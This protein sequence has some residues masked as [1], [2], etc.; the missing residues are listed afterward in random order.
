[1][2]HPKES[3]TLERIARELQE[4]NPGQMGIVAAMQVSETPHWLRER[5]WTVDEDGVVVVDR[6]DWN[7]ETSE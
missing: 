5:G 3:E 1:M 2:P 6:D 7:E 4:G